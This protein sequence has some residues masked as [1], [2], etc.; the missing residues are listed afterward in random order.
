MAC[1]GLSGSVD[2]WLTAG[3]FRGRITFGVVRPPFLAPQF[4]GER[5]TAGGRCGG[6]PLFGGVTCGFTGSRSS[7]EDSSSVA[8]VVV[9]W[10]LQTQAN[11][12]I[13][14]YRNRYSRDMGI[15]E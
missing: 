1:G 5:Q 3:G 7:L 4:A 14:Y 12:P 10:V 2:R 6:Y 9:G 8:L 13:W 11:G 15:R